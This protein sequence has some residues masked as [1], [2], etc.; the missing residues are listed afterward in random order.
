[1]DMNTSHESIPLL[2]VEIHLIMSM[3]IYSKEG[4]VYRHNV[5]HLWVS[6]NLSLLMLMLSF[7]RTVFLLHLPPEQR[8]RLTRS[9]SSTSLTR[10][11][12]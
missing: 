6:V 11:S 2:L 9:A 12:L 5:S 4:V 3:D 1:M 7:L 8:A 10:I